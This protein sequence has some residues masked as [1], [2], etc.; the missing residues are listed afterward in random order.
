MA[1]RSLYPFSTTIRVVL[2]AGLTAASLTGCAN[3]P[4]A[5][6]SYS[7]VQDASEQGQINL[8]P[9]T[10]QSM[11]P[12]PHP[13]AASFPPELRDGAEFDYERLGPGDRLQVR[14]WESG[15]GTVFSG[16]G[17][18]D[19]GEL[20]VDDE[21]RLYLPYVGAIRVAGMTVPQV[22]SAVISRLSRVVLRPQVD[23][24]AAQRR[25]T[26][27]SVQ[28][29]A[30]KTGVYPIERGRSR[31]STLLAEVAPNQKNPEMLQVTVRRDGAAGQVRLSDLYRD[32]SLDIALRPGDTIILNELVENVTV[33]GATGVQG[34]VRIPERSFSLVDVIGAARGLSDDSAD[35]R[36]VFLLRASAEGQPPIAYQLDMRRP[37]AI[38]LANRVVVKDG[39]A[40]LVS[41]APFSQTR[42]V[43]SAFSQTLGT[44]RST[45]AIIP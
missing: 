17:G 28:G 2:I 36:A 7:D 18:A 39:D 15:G 45:T 22:R 19:L 32:P 30:A 44:V 10:A 29:D 40:V 37:D 1:S 14:I 38:V 33:L 25:S 23:I 43:L 24:R 20:A 6:S 13:L 27:V 34:Q 31:L 16:T 3:L 5:V 35:P 8:V 9:L 21:G 4:R 42:K 26:L 12:A 11:P 41:A